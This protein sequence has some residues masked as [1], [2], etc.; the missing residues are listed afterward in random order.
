MR[1]WTDPL[2]AIHVFKFDGSSV[3]HT[4]RNLESP[5]YT[6]AVKHNGFPYKQFYTP[7]NPGPRPT[8]GH[9]PYP[10][11]MG[12]CIPDPYLNASGHQQEIQ[13][14]GPE[15]LAAEESLPWKPG[16]VVG[17]NPNVDIARYVAQDGKE[18][19]LA[20]TDQN[21]KLAPTNCELSL[22]CRCSLH[23]RQRTV[24]PLHPGLARE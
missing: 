5:A 1:S 9:V 16:S 10:C 8:G 3:R 6:E 24:R 23:S 17:V 22:R 21:V 12:P 15:M 20:L 13:A 2:A 4:A 19:F 11:A 7:K 14:A 18:L